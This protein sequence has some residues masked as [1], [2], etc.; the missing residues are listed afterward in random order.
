MRENRIARVLTN[1]DNSLHCWNGKNYEQII[2]KLCSIIGLE[3][4]LIETPV[5]RLVRKFEDT[6]SRTDTDTLRL[7]SNLNSL[8]SDIFPRALFIV[9]H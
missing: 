6:V 1:Y 9:T 3:T 2:G 5:C 4:A 7:V 8:L